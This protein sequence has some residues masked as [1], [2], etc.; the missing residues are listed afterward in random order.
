MGMP[1]LEPRKSSPDGLCLAHQELSQ[2]RRV[3]HAEGEAVF[4]EH[5]PV[6]FVG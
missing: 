1:R 2:E 3:N 4:L 5:V 6:T